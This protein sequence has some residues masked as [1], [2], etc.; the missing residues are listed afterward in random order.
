ML[1]NPKTLAQ[2]IKYEKARRSLTEFLKQ[3]W[4]TVD[5][6]VYEHN[7]DIDVVCEHLEAVSRGEI[8]RLLINIPPRRLKSTMCGVMWPAWEWGTRPELKYLT[9]S[10]DS[11]L[12]LRDTAKTRD[13]IKSDWY[14]E[15]INYLVRQGCIE[16]FWKLKGDQN[17]KGRY[18]NDQGGHRIA[19]TIGAPPTG[20]GGDRILIDDP[21]SALEA[22][23]K[24][25]R[26]RAINVWDQ[27]LHNRLNDQRTGVKVIVMQ[28]LHKDDLSGHVLEQ[29][30]YEHL[31]I[32]MEYRKYVRLGNVEFNP[33]ER[34]TSLGWVDKREHDGELL[35]PV[36]F[37]KP[38]VDELKSSRGLGSNAYNS[39]YQQTPLNVEGNMF[40]RSVVE[41]IDDV[42]VEGTRIRYW[43]KAGTE[44]GGKRTAGVLMLRTKDGQYIIEDVQL[45]QHGAVLREKLIK[46]TAITDAEKYGSSG[47]TIWIEQEPGSG[48]KESAEATIRNLA[49]FVVKAERPTGEKEIRAIPLSVQWAAGNVKLKKGHWNKE[50]LD[51]FEV[52]PKGSFK[53]QIDATSGAF[54]RLALTA[55]RP[56]VITL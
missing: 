44:K 27:A 45:A 11:D 43:D 40:D 1:I 9:G 12:A 18:E 36:R 7:W 47:V 8:K 17:V 30:G 19:Y 32:P 6:A 35:D 22:F 55:V 41:I 53:D 5:P 46:Q 54:N 28:R 20:D 51:E 52:F 3:A 10:Y 16:K 56:R 15:Y 33:K 23:S 4:K 42:P 13:L 38:I 26:E 50:F 48:G 37:P 49:G 14:K 29:G 34:P 25:R 2:D 21:L 24:A 31:F 39:Q